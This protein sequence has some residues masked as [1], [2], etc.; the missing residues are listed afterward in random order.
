MDEKTLRKIKERLG[1]DIAARQAH[2]AKQNAR[3]E[4]QVLVCGGSGCSSGNSKKIYDE[5]AREIKEKSL[6]GKVNLVMTGCFGLCALGPVVI[7]YPEGS[8]Y[9]N[10]KLEH[11][12]E[13]VDGHLVGGSP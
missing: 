11:V 10:V 1:S 7:I 4:R 8:F 13:I 9:A 5:F 12:E 2:L 3:F 6:I